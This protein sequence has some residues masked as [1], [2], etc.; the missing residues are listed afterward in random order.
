[1]TEEI[2]EIL[3]LSMF[4]TASSY[5]L[6]KKP[7]RLR[8]V[9]QLERLFFRII[10]ELDADLFIE[11]GAKDANS[12]RRAR[13]HLPDAKIVAFEANPY[14]YRR[15]R[16]DGANQRENI[17]YVHNALTSKN[18]KITF[19]V[20]VVEGR[21]SADGSGSLLASDQESKPV[22]VDAVRMDTYFEPVQAKRIALWVDVEGANKDVFEGA[23]GIMDAVQVAFVEVQD[24]PLWEG[25]WL[26]RDVSRHL[27]SRGFVPFA[28]DYQSRYL[29]NVIYIK[30]EL[31][32]T[33]RIRHFLSEHYASQ[34]RKSITT[35]KR[36]GL[37][38][39]V[40]QLFRRAINS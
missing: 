28:R 36:K 16:N 34:T 11:A 24:R 13:R 39:R 33:P 15:F 30:R 31:I 27:Y 32:W 26:T 7:E 6:T 18:G 40:R 10:T 37:K 19:N 14:T 25:Q 23:D 1:M 8:S 38:S 20:R 22:T 5:D 3:D 2:L 4:A 35:A 21:P 9:N 29:Y 12:S 17:D